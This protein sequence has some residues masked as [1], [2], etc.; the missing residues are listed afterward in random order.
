MSTRP[1]HRWRA[2][3]INLG[4][5]AALLTG[6]SFLPPDTSLADRQS[7]G[8]LKLCVPPS[9]PPLVTG[10]EGAPG[11]DVELA[12]AIAAA[13][14]LKLSLNVLPSIGQDYNP[15]NWFLT[16]AQCDIV[17][18]GVADTA[19]TRSFMQTVPTQAR[20]GWIGISQTGTMPPAGSVVAVLPGTSGL[21]R[22]VLSGWLRQQ[23]LRAQLVRSPAELSR[24][25]TSG[26]AGAA[27][28]ERFLADGID[29]DQTGLMPFWLEGEGFTSF[30]MGLGVWK[31]DQTLKRAIDAAVSDL[32]ES[33][34][35]ERLRERYGVDADLTPA[36]T[37]QTPPSAGSPLE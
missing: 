1:K 19:Q 29:L 10:E 3:A 28:T 21:N 37:N 4:I 13:L 12:G 26:A 24:A 14:D 25:L 32:E 16:R 30:P 2:T 36:S 8:V 11:Y 18:G 9:F 6:L 5:V 35:M 15:R 7:A 20:T 34:A 17:G 33:G 22:L 31:G 23:Q 27:V